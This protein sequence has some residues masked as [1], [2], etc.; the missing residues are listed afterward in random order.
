MSL[1]KVSAWPALLVMGPGGAWAGADTGGSGGVNGA[2]TRSATTQET[3]T[4]RG[5]GGTRRGDTDR[6]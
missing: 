2:A 1:F 4:G 3:N 5:V 6:G